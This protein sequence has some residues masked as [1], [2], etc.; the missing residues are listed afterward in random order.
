MK[1]PR[2]PK[3]TLSIDFGSKEIKVLEGKYARDNIRI[4]KSITIQVEPHFYL[5]GEILDKDILSTIIKEELKENNI[6][7]STVYG[8]INSSKIITREIIIPK[9]SQNEIKSVVNYQVEDYLP[10]NIEDYVV[11]Y[12]NL[13]NI[14]EGEIERIKILLFAI[15]K[16]M[17]L[18]HLN[19]LRDCGLKPEILDYQGNA[20]SKLLSF[21]GKVNEDYNTRDLSIASVDIGYSNSKLTIV[22]NGKT[23]VTR[24][25]DT[26]GKV[27]YDN[28]MSFF[29]YSIEEIEEKLMDIEDLNHYQDEFSDKSRFSNIVRTTLNDICEKLEIVFRYY[30]T[31]ETGNMVNYILLQGGYSYINGADNVFSAYFNIPSMQ[32]S[33]LDKI[34]WD[35]DLSRYVNAIGGLIRIDEV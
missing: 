13:G 18:S 12:L 21:N 34:K 24:V 5:D 17:V 31:R 6:S 27:L 11:Q 35:G 14:I 20:I 3:R 4:L 15:P 23:E 2:V 10:V 25:I 8:I 30:N 16:D 29:D 7:T 28:I 26:G 19:L 32:L 1:L 33:T 9:V 22:K